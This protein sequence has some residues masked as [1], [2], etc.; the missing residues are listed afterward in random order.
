MYVCYRTEM[1][2]THLQIL[3]H[4]WGKQHHQKNNPIPENMEKSVFSI[5]FKEQNRLNCR[6]F[7]IV[8]VDSKSTPPAA[9]VRRSNAWL[10]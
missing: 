5:H 3:F 1:G 4:I 7:P 6:T 2:E 10:Q 9:P 8:D